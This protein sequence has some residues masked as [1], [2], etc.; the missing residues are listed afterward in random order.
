LRFFKVPFPPAPGQSF[1]DDG[2]RN[3]V[4]KLVLDQ[5]LEFYEPYDV[6]GYDAYFQIPGYNRNWITPVNLAN[7]YLFSRWLIEN[8]NRGGTG[9]VIKADLVSFI[10][11]PQHVANPSD[12]AS[13]VK[14]F[15]DYLLA[16]ELNSDRFNYFL[17]TIFLESLAAYNWTNEWNSY[18]AGGSN[19]IVKLRLETL[20]TKI[21]QTPEFQ[22]F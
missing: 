7:R 12:A 2:Y 3:G 6:A 4:G 5:G 9:E 22:L 17:N 10:D 19:A 11:N 8:I 14:V 13:V 1:Y 15:T 21:I 20:V 18:K 16:V